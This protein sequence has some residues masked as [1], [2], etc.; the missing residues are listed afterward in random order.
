MITD[1]TADS[2]IDTLAILMSSSLFLKAISDTNMD[3]V[4]PIPASKETV[5]TDNQSTPLGLSVILSL[6]AIQVND[7]MP[8]GLPIT[9]PATIPSINLKS[10]KMFDP[11]LKLMLVLTSANKGSIIKLQNGSN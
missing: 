11:N 1:M 3:I 8:N 7:I 10:D 2:K 9:K 4:N 6:V 5:N